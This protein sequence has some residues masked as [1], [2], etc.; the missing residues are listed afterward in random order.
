MASSATLRVSH[1]NQSIIEIA[2]ANKTAF[3]IVLAPVF[4]FEVRTFKDDSGI[5]KV[6]TSGR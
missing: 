2:E 5:F 6:K 1:D 4:G 3:A